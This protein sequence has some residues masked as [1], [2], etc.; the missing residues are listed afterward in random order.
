VREQLKRLQTAAARAVMHPML[1]HDA[2]AAIAESV[3]LVAVIVERL[4]SLERT[5][6]DGSN[7][8]D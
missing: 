3:A 8:P 1:P 7:R 6:N 5:V 4:E 2:R